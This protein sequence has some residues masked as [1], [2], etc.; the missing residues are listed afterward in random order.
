MPCERLPFGTHGTITLTNTKAGTWQASTYYRGLDGVRRRLRRTASTRTHAEIALR[1]Y[2]AVILTASG[3]VLSPHSTVANAVR[4]W[5]DE[6]NAERE[7]PSDTISR[8]QILLDKHL[9]PWFG[10]LR[11]LECTPSLIQAHLSEAAKSTG[12]PTLKVV[13]SLL[14]QVFDT[15][16]RHDAISRNPAKAT[17][18]I[19]PV[20]KPVQVL[21]ME[22]VQ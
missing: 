12:A 5:W 15:A 7:H 10:A 14:G 8:Y 21:S 6:W 20:K 3:T 22:Q 1:E 16:I 13:R 2:A 4:V 18:G 11:L 9:L 19:N 17:K